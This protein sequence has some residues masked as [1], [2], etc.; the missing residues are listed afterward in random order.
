[1]SG[2]PATGVVVDTM[3]IS[4]LLN[5]RPEDLAGR[6]RDLIGANPVLL[7]NVHGFHRLDPFESRAR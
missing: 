3:V 1:M 6:Y 4:W 7:V 5:D 2:G